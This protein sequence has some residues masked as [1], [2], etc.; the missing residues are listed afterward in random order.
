M[1]LF[2]AVHNVYY[3][4]TIHGMGQCKIQAAGAN[5]DQSD[6]FFGISLEV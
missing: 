2:I 1:I 6:T 4:G 5:Y 3:I